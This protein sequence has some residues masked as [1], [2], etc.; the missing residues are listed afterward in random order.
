MFRIIIEYKY[1]DALDKTRSKV[2][3]GNSWE[4]ASEMLNDFVLSGKVAWFRILSIYDGT[5]KGEDDVSS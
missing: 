1:K 2:I 4:D 5:N 3:I